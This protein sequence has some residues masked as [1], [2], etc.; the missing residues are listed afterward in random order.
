MSKLNQIKQALL[1]MDAGE[2]QKLADAYLAEQKYGNINSIGSV[3][4][5]NKVRKGTP[6]NLIVTPEGNYIFSEH[7]TQQKGLLSKMQGDLE[8][9]FDENE[10][11][12]PIKKIERIIFCFTGNLDPLEINELNDR[13]Q[14]KGVILDL[15]GIDTLAL[16][17]YNKYPGIALDFLNVSIDTDQIV[18]PERFL[19]LYNKNK[20]TTRLDFNFHFREKELDCLLN[21]L[22]SEKLVFLSGQ[23]GVGKSRLAL[24]AC[25]IFS[26]AHP[27]YEVKC[28]F[29]KGIDLWQ[30][31]Q[32]WFTKPGY[33]LIFVDDANRADRFEYIVDLLLYQREDQRIKVIVTVRDYALKK[34]QEESRPLGKISVLNLERF[35]NEQIKGLITEECGIRSHFFQERIIDIAR[36]NP[37]LA[38][39]AAEVAKESSF[40][41]IHDVSALYDIYFSSIRDDLRVEGADPQSA[42]LLRTVAIVSFFNAVDRSNETMMNVIEDAFG[43]TPA[44]FWETAYRLNELEILDMYEDEIVKISDQVLGTYLFYLA[45]FKEKILD[46]GSLLR[47]FFPKMQSRIIDS[48]KPVLSAFDTEHI[49]DTMRPDIESIK[50]KLEAAGD[51]KKLLHLLDVFWFIIPTYTLNWVSDQIN[52]LKHEPAEPTS[53]TFE[54]DSNALSSPSILSILGNFA[55]I[56]DDDEPDAR[57]ALELLSRYLTKRPAEAPGLLK[58]LID[59]Y[60]FKHD[61]YLW[62]FEIQQAVVDE[63]Y[64]RLKG[65]DP[66]FMRMFLAVAKNHLGINFENQRME[67][68]RTIKFR[69]FDLPA[70]PEIIALREKMWQG[71]FAIYKQ[72]EDL[73]ENVLEVISY[74]SKLTFRGTE[75]NKELVKSDAANVLPFLESELEPKNYL[76]CSLMHDYLDLLVILDLEVPDGLRDQFRNETF[77]IAEI[78]LLNWSELRKSNLLVEEYEQQQQGRLE[79][80]TSSYTLDDYTRFFHHCMEIQKAPDGNR[81]KKHHLQKGVLNALLSLADRNADLF[82]RVLE[83]YFKLKDPFQLEGNTLVKKLFEHKGHKGTMELLCK[84]AYPTKRKWLFYAHEVLPAEEISKDD[85]ARLYKLYESAEAVDIPRGLDYLLK[86]L[87]LDSRIITRVVSLLLDKVEGDSSFVNAL[88]MLFNPHTEITNH[89]SDLFSKDIDLLK[90]SYLVVENK[91]EYSD[92]NGHAFNRLLDLD[93]VFIE[94]YIAWKYD[95]AE[96]KCLIRHDVHRN[97][98]F[99]WSRPDHQEVMNRVVK[100]VYVRNCYRSSFIDPYLSSFFLTRGDDEPEEKERERQDAYILRLIDERSE[101]INFMKYLFGVISLFTP[102]RRLLFIKRFVR[103]NDNFEVFKGL[104]LEPNSWSSIGSLVPVLQRRVDYWKSLLQIMNTVDL[105]QH[106]QYI[107]NQIQS[108][109]ASIEREKKN[110]FIRD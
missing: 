86:Y 74:Y 107:N 70:D 21:A 41:S 17:L 12:V 9:C 79:E 62:K 35:T 31:L 3:T 76:H 106:K 77:T 6:D 20:L 50:N 63:M 45:M 85:L 80:H 110:D 98:S 24:E 42:D 94:E 59:I 82:G 66:I 89:L 65:G 38:V 34:L 4:A 22:E 13:C 47:H 72:E 53:I 78:V 48:I 5:A 25:R 102:T 95:N 8:K 83:H 16:D 109:H 1:E 19:L 30:D 73:R 64:K 57:I 54:K 99:I 18:S 71:L 26:D 87:P 37:R 46:F 93:P 43:V 27:D 68:N 29:S 60:G 92:Y 58:V 10:T 69:R 33:F 75:N 51:E 96:H 23:A 108:L 61:S 105:L 103:L 49:I 7:T 84:Q 15:F 88:T 56:G 100:S 67:D 81:D 14:K 28:V 44:A 36:G 39:M 40:D 11:G 55:F 91:Q 52:E 101:D 90:R 97:F 32:V 104:S 2:F